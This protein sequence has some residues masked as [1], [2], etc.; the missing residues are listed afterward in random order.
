LQSKVNVKV[1]V[2]SPI[3]QA[4]TNRCLA[5]VEQWDTSRAAHSQRVAAQEAKVQRAQKKAGGADAAKDAHDSKVSSTATLTSS[6]KIH[7]TVT[8]DVLSLY[9]HKPPTLQD[10]T[11]IFSTCKQAA[12]VR[13]RKAVAQAKLEQLQCALA[14]LSERR[15]DLLSEAAAAQVL[16]CLAPACVCS[17]GPSNSTFYLE[18]RQPT[19]CGVQ[20]WADALQQEQRAVAA[21]SGGR[22]GKDALADLCRQGDDC[23][24]LPE[25]IICHKPRQSDLEA[26]AWLGRSAGRQHLRALL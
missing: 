2:M 17:C 7:F 4:D 10:N 20:E 22:P 14:N 13:E 24:K 25:P 9:A 16:A 11:N 1:C 23:T 8:A 26:C 5:L 3:D 21:C 6:V 19:P 12:S 15:T 18:V